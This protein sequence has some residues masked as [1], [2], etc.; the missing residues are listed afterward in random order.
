MGHNIGPYAY[1]IFHT[2]MGRPIRVWA[3]I[4]IWGKKGSLPV[5][6]DS[7]DSYSKAQ[8]EDK[9]CSKLIEYCTSGWPTRTELPRELKDYWRYRGELTVNDNLLLYN[10]RIVVP[11]TMRQQTLQRSTRIIRAFK[12]VECVSST[13]SGGQGYQNQLRI[14]YNLAPFIRRQ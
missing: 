7:L 4:H 2:C 12:D 9:I 5:D 11:T 6:Q 8:I 14:L 1:G 3:N 13:L 10:S